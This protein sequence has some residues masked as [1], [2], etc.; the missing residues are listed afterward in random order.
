VSFLLDTNVISELRRARPNRRVVDWFDSVPASRVF[1][2]VMVIGELRQGVERLSRRDPARAEA[3]GQWLGQL[4]TTYGDRIAPVTT[5]VAET[6]GRLNGP[7]Q[8]PV[9]D[10]LLAATALVRDWTLVTRN[11]SDMRSTGARLLDPFSA[12]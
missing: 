7:G 5:E 9:V 12:N 8:V 10:G 2:S 1:L 3:I 4:L 11:I 6:W